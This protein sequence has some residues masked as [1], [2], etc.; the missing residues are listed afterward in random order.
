MSNLQQQKQQ[1]PYEG[2]ASSTKS[3]LPDRAEGADPKE[4]LMPRMQAQHTRMHRV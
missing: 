4:G 3:L 1:Q 2:K